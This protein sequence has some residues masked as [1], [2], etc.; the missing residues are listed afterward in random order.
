MRSMAPVGRP[1]IVLA[2]VVGLAGCGS[3]AHH[4]NPAPTAHRAA[5]TDPMSVLRPAARLAADDADD[6][7]EPHASTSQVSD[8]RSVVTHFFKTYLAFLFGRLPARRVT[9]VDHALRWQLAHGHATFTPAER[10]ARPRVSHLSL[11]SAG[12]PVSVV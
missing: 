10:T 5:P 9:G 6:D 11:S 12:P 7:A 2:L 8:A 4:R 1:A 3:H